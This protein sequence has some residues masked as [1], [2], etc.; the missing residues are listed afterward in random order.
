MSTRKPESMSFKTPHEVDLGRTLAPLRHGVGDPS[1]R[2][3][4]LGVWRAT[5][6]PA[7]PSTVLIRRDGDYIR[8]T[9][10]GEGAEWAIE[11]APELT[12]CAELSDP[13]EP[14]HEALRELH[15]A[16]PG[17]RIPRSRA[18]VEA[19]V[20]LIIEQKVLG[21]EAR[22]GYQ[23]MVRSWGEPAPGPAGLILPVAPA[24]LS[25]QPYFAFHRFG[26]ERTRADT[27]RRSCTCA[28]RLET[29]ADL[30]SLEGQR[31][32]RI[33]EGVGRWTASEVARVAFADSDAVPLGDYHLP[34]LVSW[35][36][37]EKPREANP[38]CW[39]CWSR[40]GDSGASRCA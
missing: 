9:A 22:C 17:V 3:E 10:W 7:G 2:I 27:I 4:R 8:V 35:V 14:K 29:A 37:W 31:R 23:R 20:P 25:R 40:I 13:F 19:L 1:V 39:S 36:C 33:V 26:L 38:G 30:P 11:A 28:S 12:G 18:V 32:L 34:N 15:R 24:E 16:M 5:R 6:T 21:A